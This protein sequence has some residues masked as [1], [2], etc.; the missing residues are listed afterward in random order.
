M[1]NLSYPAIIKQDED[2][3]FQVSFP[4]FPGCVTFGYSY[5]EAFRNA[6]DVLK[7]WILEVAK[8]DARS[9]NKMQSQTVISNI[10]VQFA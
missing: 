2:K 5:E 3:V 1:S 8:S 6:E 7:L 10:S 4:D 9:I